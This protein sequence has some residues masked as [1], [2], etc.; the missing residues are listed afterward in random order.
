MVLDGDWLPHVAVSHVA[1][2]LL[3]SVDA[4]EVAAFLGV[5]RAKVSD[6]TDD[7]HAAV[8]GQGL[9]DY[10]ESVAHYD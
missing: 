7:V 10:L 9:R 8:R 1:D 2:L 3:V 6:D 5:F 4:E